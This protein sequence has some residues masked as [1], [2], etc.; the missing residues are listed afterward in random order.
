MEENHRINELASQAALDADS[1][2]KQLKNE[3]DRHAKLLA[4]MKEKLDEK[5]DYDAIKKELRYELSRSHMRPR[6]QMK[7]F[8]LFLYFES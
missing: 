3:R 4:E 6:P 7:C 8:D 2:A 1:H 5:H